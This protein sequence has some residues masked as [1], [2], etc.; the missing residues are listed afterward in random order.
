[1]KTIPARPVARASVARASVARSSVA[2][3][4][5]V[6]GIVLFGADG[7]DDVSRNS[8]APTSSIATD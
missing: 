7:G 2:R 3:S 6:S 8:P 5:D 1:M 4:S